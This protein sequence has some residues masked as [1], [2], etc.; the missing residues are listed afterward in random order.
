[1][2]GFAKRIQALEGALQIATIW[3][4]RVETLL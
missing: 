1:M 3:N 2:L 4:Y